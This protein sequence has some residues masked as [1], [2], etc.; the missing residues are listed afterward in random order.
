M[1]F[2]TIYSWRIVITG[3][4]FQQPNTIVYYVTSGLVYPMSVNTSKSLSP[5]ILQ[6]VLTKA[7]TYQ[8]RLYS[9]AAILRVQPVDE[10]TRQRRAG[11]AR[12][13]YATG[14]NPWLLT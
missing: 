2:I 12:T 8:I 9:S 4:V 13:G 6:S 11:K 1:R 10:V 5:H 14:F 7:N 3:R